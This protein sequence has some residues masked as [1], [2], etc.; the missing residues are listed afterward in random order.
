MTMF[1]VT[2]QPNLIAEAVRLHLQESRHNQDTEALYLTEQA[3]QLGQ[4]YLSSGD[5]TDLECVALLYEEALC[6]IG[7]QHPARCKIL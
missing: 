4:K 1:L 7:K 5:I 3:S 6:M 2:G